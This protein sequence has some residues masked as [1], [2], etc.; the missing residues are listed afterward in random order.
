[1]DSHDVSRRDLLKATALAGAGAVVLP[2]IAAAGAPGVAA[3]QDVRGR[4]RAVG[5]AHRPPARLTGRIVTP[6][7][8][9]YADASLGW[10]QFFVH[11]PLVIVFAQNTQDVVN[12]LTWAQQNNVAFRVRSGRHQLQGWNAVDNGL[13]IDVSELKST[14]IDTV[15]RTATVGAGIN[16]L[17]AVTALAKKGLVVPTGTE[18]TVGVVGATVGGGLG[19]FTRSL[20][21]ACDYVTG[22]EIVVASRDG[23]ARLINVDLRSH[24]DLL[25]ALR[26]AGNGNFGVITSLTYQATRAPTVA[27]L[28]AT[29]DAPYDLQRI[30]SAYQGTLFARNLVGSELELHSKQAILTAALPNGSVARV[31]AALA[32]VLSIG[33]PTVT[34]TVDSWGTI[35]AGFQIPPAAEP[36][37]ALFFSQFA[38]RPFPRKAIDVVA[39]F[40]KTAP[41]DDSNYFLCGF[42]GAV[43][44][45]APRGGTAFPHRDA[46]FYAEPGVAWG[47]PR[48]PGPFTF[49]TAGE[50]SQEEVQP[51]AQAWISEFSQAL[52]PYV[53]GAYANVPNVGMLDWETAYWGSNFDRLRRIKSTYDPH[54]IFQYEQS[55]RP[56]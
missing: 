52:R 51:V 21:M 32:S 37:N 29:W 10:D 4:A 30:L 35:F 54:N 7:D 3:A 42:G 41:T 18:G 14:R 12:A 11:F 25:F 15:A 26:G 5:D 20:G 33:K 23:G 48:G 49:E 16:Q 40:V 22:A 6:R 50:E 56:A 17:E 53:N 47:K 8:P 28:M 19:L 9:G 36:G 44:R 31:K 1:V 2:G 24:R 45:S 55:V 13:V 34:S 39:S 43:K 38:S 27:F 46:L